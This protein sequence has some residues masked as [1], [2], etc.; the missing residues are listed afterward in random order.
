MG[1]GA[2][3]R[4]G[5]VGGGDPGG[6]AAAGATSLAGRLAGSVRL[7]RRVY[8]ELAADAAATPQALWLVALLG[9]A[10]AAGGAMRGL[11]FGWNP[12]EG[13]AFGLQGELVFFVVASVVIHLLG[14]FALGGA[15]SYG[16]VVRPLAF[17]S[18]PGFLVLVAAV[19]SLVSPP[20][21]LA[22]FPAIIA[23]RLAAGFVAVREALGL[24]TARSVIA[25]VAGVVVGVVAVGVG[26][27]GLVLLLK[28]A[29]AES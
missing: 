22:V 26:S 12:W 19:L 7:D 6:S 13:A 3:T 8:S 21:G 29:G 17:S 18:V 5:A 14:R 25:V 9:A 2:G 28:W 23:W 16:R 15:A 1:H 27:G 4:P 20:A 10:H 24:S 11:A